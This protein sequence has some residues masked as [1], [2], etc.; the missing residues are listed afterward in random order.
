MAIP[1]GWPIE[2][3]EAIILNISIKVGGGGGDYSREA[4]NSGTAII[5][6]NTVF[7]LIKVSARVISA[8][9]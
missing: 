7:A 9:Q 2:V 5:Q 8:S 3:G 1:S 6:R 4:I